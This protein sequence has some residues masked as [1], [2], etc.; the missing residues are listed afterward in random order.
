MKNF[1]KFVTAP[2][3]R[4]VLRRLVYDEGFWKR[5]LGMAWGDKSR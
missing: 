5:G 1:G 3:G 4:L 2:V